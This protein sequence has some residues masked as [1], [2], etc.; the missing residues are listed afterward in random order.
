MR[1]MVLS[2][3]PL[4]SHSE[5]ETRLAVTLAASCHGSNARG[6]DLEKRL[7]VLHDAHIN[8]LRS[9]AHRQDRGHASL[10]WTSCTYS[11]VKE[12]VAHRLLNT[13]PAPEVDERPPP[14]A[15]YL[16]PYLTILDKN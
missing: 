16:R 8:K 15:S 14:E 7:V 12:E 11:A 6:P 1:S 3:D 10:K 9:C 4:D 13:C 2:P 5:C